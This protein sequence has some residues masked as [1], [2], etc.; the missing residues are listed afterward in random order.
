[1][2][3]DDALRR[4]QQDMVATYWREWGRL[5]EEFGRPLSG[6]QWTALYPTSG[7]EDDASVRPPRSG[8]PADPGYVPEWAEEEA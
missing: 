6:E 4:L 5:L 7:A 3:T 8:D 2:L 1:M